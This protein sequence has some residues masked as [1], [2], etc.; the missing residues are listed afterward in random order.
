MCHYLGNAWD[1]TLFNCWHKWNNVECT[2]QDAC[3]TS[4]SP[5]AYKGPQQSLILP[6]T[7]DVELQCAWHFITLTWTSIFTSKPYNNSAH[8]FYCYM[9]KVFTPATNDLVF[10][11]FWWR[12]AKYLHGNVDLWRKFSSFLCLFHDIYILPPL[13]RDYKRINKHQWNIRKW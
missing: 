5:G 10:P 3:Q 4:N 1:P 12:C 2:C 13:L 6:G 9:Y 7:D 11:T 8:A